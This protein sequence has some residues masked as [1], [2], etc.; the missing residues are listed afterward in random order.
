MKYAVIGYVLLVLVVGILVTLVMPEQS[1]EEGAAAEEHA[2]LPAE[3]TPAPEI[4]ERV[5]RI[6]GRRFDGEAPRIEAVPRRD[7]EERLARLDEQPAGDPDLAEGAAILLAQAG[8]V[9]AEQAE[10]LAARRH[11]GT[12]LLASYVPEENAVLVD[13]EYAR[14]DPEGAEAAA[15]GE[16]SRALDTA[17]E[18]APRIPPFLRDDEAAR[19]TLVGGAATLVAGEYAEVHLRAEADVGA[20]RES[21]RDPETPPALETLLRVPETIGARF[22][23]GARRTGGRSAIDEILGDP[24]TTTNALLHPDPATGVRSPG[25]DVSRE[26]RGWRRATRADVGELDT[27]VLLRSGVSERVAFKS[28]A[29]WRA[30]RFELW[31]RGGERCRPPCRRGAVSIVVHRWGDVA[32]AT[33]FNRAMRDALIGGD[34][35]ATPEGGRGFTIGDGGAALVRAGRFTALVF[36]PDAP[37]AGRVAERALEG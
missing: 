8:A 18:E 29:G 12:G 25:F 5:G 16:L 4:A 13:A 1:E 20:A 35:Q 6:R 2:A 36:A 19:V 37:L 21:L 15:A 14:S 32:D 17:G 24:P 23:Q 22:L 30:G 27:A 9:P 28:A 11:G 3:I 34:A 33:T 10:E 31:T 26:L 7:L